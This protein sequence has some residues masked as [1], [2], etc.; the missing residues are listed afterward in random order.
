MC[1]FEQLLTQFFICSDNDQVVRP[2]VKMT[3][4]LSAFAAEVPISDFYS[5]AIKGKTVAN[6]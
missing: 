1:F 3:D 4:C 2:I 6:Q 5:S